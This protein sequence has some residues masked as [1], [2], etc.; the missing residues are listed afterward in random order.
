MVM[1][2]VSENR[3]KCY[4]CHRTFPDME[5]LREHQRQVHSGRSV[6]HSREPAPGD[7]SIF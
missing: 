3:P 7:V 1:A 6:Q 2:L 4:I 5:K